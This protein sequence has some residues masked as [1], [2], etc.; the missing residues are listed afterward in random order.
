[1][2]ITEARKL[3]PG[4]YEFTFKGNTTDIGVVGIDSDNKPWYAHSQGE[5]AYDSA[6]S[7]QH[8]TRLRNVIPSNP[9]LP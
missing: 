9:R 5:G 4:I 2:T 1:M 6:K 8:V 7:W 3:V